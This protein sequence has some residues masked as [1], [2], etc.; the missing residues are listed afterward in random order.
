M[1]KTTKSGGNGSDKPKVPEG[2]P[3]SWHKATGQF[4]KRFSGKF[5]YFGRD[6]DAA[7]KRYLRE[8]DYLL[9]GQPVPEESDRLTVRRLV[10]EFLATKEARIKSGQLSKR[11]F[12]ELLAVG[13]TLAEVFGDR[14]VPTLAPRDFETLRSR[15]PSGSPVVLKNKLIRVRSI[16]RYATENGMIDK[17]VRFGTGLDLPSKS[18]LRRHRGK[19]AVPLFTADQIRMFLDGREST[20]KPG[21]RIA[22]AD[23]KMRAWLLLGLNCGFYASDISALEHRHIIGEFVDF[24]RP[25]S[26]VPRRCWL[27]HETRE[28]L[29]A[30][31]ESTDGLMF[32][33]ERGRKLLEPTE[34]DGGRCDAVS[35]RFRSLKRR[36]QFKGDTAGFKNLRHSFRT[37]ADGAKDEPAANL[38]MG[39]ADNH[40]SDTYRH[41]IDD[42][43][44]RAVS[45][46]VR[47]WLWP[48]ANETP[49]KRERQ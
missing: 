7:L 22:G 31:V 14:S 2:F 33:N 17:P 28:A 30:A 49:S 8:K 36:L 6:P 35:N 18:E 37:I 34:G 23:A 47:R 9:A 10:N 26:G 39:H 5:V 15:F 42:E 38:I 43:R 24:P 19:Q 11:T 4:Y 1:Q 12:G 20:E 21:E 40:I 45:E 44:L 46:F 29:A 48:N 13:R 27:W 32:R 3:L 41:T 25:K 16:F